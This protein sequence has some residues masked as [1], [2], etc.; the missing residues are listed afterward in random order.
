MDESV[1]ASEVADDTGGKNVESSRLRGFR[2]RWESSEFRSPEHLTVGSSSGHDI[3]D[4][5]SEQFFQ[6]LDEQ[7]D[8]IGSWSLAEQSAD[9]APSTGGEP[10]L[11]SE[12]KVT[13]TGDAEHEYA[14][15]LQALQSATKRARLYNEKF[16]WESSN[17]NGVFG[18][19]DPFTNTIA[20]GHRHM[21]APAHEGIYDV[22]QSEMSSGSHNISIT[23]GTEAASPPVRR[24][25]LLGRA[26][27]ETPDENIRRVALAKLRD[28]I[29]GDPSAT[30][31]GVSLQHLLSEGSMSHVIEQSFS[32]CFRSKASSTL[33]KRANSLWKL[34]LLFAELGV[35]HP[36]RFSEDELYS[37]LCLMREKGMGATSGQRVIEALHFLD[38]AAGFALCNIGDIISG[39]CRGVARDMPLSKDPFNQ[40]HP[41]TV[42]QVE[43]LEHLIRDV[44]LASYFSAYTVAVV[45]VTVKD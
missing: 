15:K 11:E 9:Y 6:G 40:K 28:L 2:K 39:R 38:G 12:G 32:D 7:L 4:F 36:L 37:A 34:S 5:N 22:L 43:W 35:L 23:A 24:I 1:S 21:F 17:L 29:M 20:S 33:Q 45:G 25:V 3:P 13:V 27:R 42:E 44:S 31:L 18:H 8:D 41:L 16:P 26:R 19:A 10:I 30:R 14:W